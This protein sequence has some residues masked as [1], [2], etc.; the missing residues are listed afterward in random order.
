M[1][2]EI[3]LSTSINHSQA[4]LRHRQ[5]LLDPLL[6]P[7]FVEACTWQRRLSLSEYNHQSLCTSF[8]SVNTVIHLQLMSSCR[9]V[10]WWQVRAKRVGG[11]ERWREWCTLG[12]SFLHAW[13][14]LSVFHM[15][16]ERCRCAAALV[17]LVGAGLHYKSRSQFAA[18]HYLINSSRYT[19]LHFSSLTT[20]HRL[21][22]KK[23]SLC[24]CVKEKRKGNL[25][26]LSQKDFL[27]Q[28][29]WI[30]YMHM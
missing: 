11:M 9:N 2:R 7:L 27:I 21:K 25:K 13:S 26:S 29:I 8:T 20:G 16:A 4:F 30:C 1:I 19:C 23:K 14:E 6:S 22:K 18:G 5:I 10:F 15:K 28:V 17:W 3:E 24:V 12:S